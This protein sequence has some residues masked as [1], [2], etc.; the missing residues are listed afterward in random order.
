[1]IFN[2]G[3]PITEKKM[4][5]TNIIKKEYFNQFLSTSSIKNYNLYLVEEIHLHS[6]FNVRTSVY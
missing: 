6:Y 2:F 3:I 1:M 5:T 4:K